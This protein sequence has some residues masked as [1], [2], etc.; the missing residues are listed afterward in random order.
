M[1]SMVLFQTATVM[2][3]EIFITIAISSAAA[4]AMTFAATAKFE[5]IEKGEDS[6]HWGTRNG[7]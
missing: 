4:A 1:D 2:V 6:N 5:H 7:I 3:I